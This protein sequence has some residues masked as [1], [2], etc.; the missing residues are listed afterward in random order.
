ASGQLALPSMRY[1]YD[2]QSDSRVLL[3][4]AGRLWSAGGTLCWPAV[5]A[6]PSELLMAPATEMASV[7][8]NDEGGLAAGASSLPDVEVATAGSHRP[9]EIEVRLAALWRELLKHDSLGPDANFFDGG[10]NSLIA[11][12]LI[13]RIRKEFGVSLRMQMIFEAP[14]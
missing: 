5:Q 8:A 2:A 13:M 14:T 3:Q 9:N 10:G 12:R 4:T 1:H 6:A 11:T 7:M